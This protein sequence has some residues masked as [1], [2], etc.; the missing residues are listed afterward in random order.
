MKK[1]NKFMILTGVGTFL[2]T[3]AQFIVSANACAS[4]AGETEIPDILK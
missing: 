2:L 3:F 4:M 1:I